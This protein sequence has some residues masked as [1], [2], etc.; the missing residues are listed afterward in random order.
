MD[1]QPQTQGQRVH[2]LANLGGLVVLAGLENLS[3]DLLLGMLMT[4]QKQL[5]VL[6]PVKKSAL[7]QLGEKALKARASHKRSFKAWQKNLE[8]ERFDFSKTQME[9]L[10]MKLG[11]SVPTLTKD[12]SAELQRLVE[13]L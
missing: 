7:Q 4:A 10:I 3:P 9:K 2:Y 13:A 8:A 12:I 6:P 5:T 1:N 11:G